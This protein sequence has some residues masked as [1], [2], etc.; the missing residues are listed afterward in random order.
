[1]IVMIVA[2][3]LYINH[4]KDPLTIN[5][6]IKEDGI[7]LGNKFY[8]YKEI[9]NFW[10]IYET[11]TKS[12]YFDFESNWRPRLSVPIINQDPLQIRKI[13]LKYLAE[14]LEQ[15]EEPLSETLSRFL[16]L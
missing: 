8:P 16:K 5:F 4:K 1:M 11:P 15:K 14:D 10:I 7:V 13:L 9:K 12:L 2:I 3:I 6:Q